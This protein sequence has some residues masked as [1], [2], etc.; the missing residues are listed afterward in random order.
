MFDQIRRIWKDSK[1]RAK[2]I[3]TRRT[4]PEEDK[5]V[6]R[7]TEWLMT[8]LSE[9]LRSL[10]IEPPRIT[11]DEEGNA[12]VPDNPYGLMAYL[13]RWDS[14]L[15]DEEKANLDDLYSSIWPMGT[16]VQDFFE[17]GDE[18]DEWSERNGIGA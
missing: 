2:V 13:A 5:A 15:T 4:V 11:L 3:N 7:P 6:G 8:K 16:S 14:L 1:W 18:P 9:H 10:G 12:I 17:A